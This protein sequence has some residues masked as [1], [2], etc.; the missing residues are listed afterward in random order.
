MTVDVIDQ[1]L[2]TYAGLPFEKEVLC[3]KCLFYLPRKEARVWKWQFIR[4]A[5]NRGVDQLICDIGKY[6]IDY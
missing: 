3:P 5:A 6:Q 2:N 4:S 1:V